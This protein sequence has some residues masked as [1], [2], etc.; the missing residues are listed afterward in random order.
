ML[1]ALEVRNAKPKEKAY[2]LN[3]GKGLF[4]HVATS[5][6]K[7]WRYR[8]ELPPGTESTFVVGEYPVLSLEAARAERVALRELV[9][10][11]INPVD[12]RRQG[13]QEA[14]AAREAEKK[15]VENSFEAVAADWHQHQKDRWTPDHAEAVLKS[16]ERYAFEPLGGVQI[17]QITSTNGVGGDSGN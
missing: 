15:M 2:K 10:S 16:L 13:K 8:F 5:G 12:A 9:K 17:D 6:K 14:I 3:D 7:T 4:L 1:T 11:G